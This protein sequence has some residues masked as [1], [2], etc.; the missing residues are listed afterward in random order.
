M[1]EPLVSEDVLELCLSAAKPTYVYSLARLMSTA[2]SI[3]DAFR[4]QAARILFAT[5]A[6]PRREILES[7]ASVGI[8][9]CVNSV[10]HLRASIEAGMP[11]DQIQFTSSGLSVQD[12]RELAKHQIQCNVD[13][14]GQ[15]EA[16]ATSWP[17]GTFGVRINTRLLMGKDVAPH[18]RLGMAPADVPAATSIGRA[19]G[20][21]MNG[22][23]IYIGTNF[24]S[25]AAMLPALDAFFDLA[26][27]VP[28][29]DYVNIGGGM[30][31]DYAME[32]GGFDVEAYAS[33]VA[34]RLMRLST[35]LRRPVQLVVEP[36]R[37]MVASCGFFTCRVTDIKE[38]GGRMFVGVDAS[39]AQ[40][41]RPWHH[42]ETP[43]Q[44]FSAKALLQNPLP[45]GPMREVVIAGRT[46]YSKDVLSTGVLP[47]DLK[48]GDSLIFAHAGAYCDS[49]ASR[50]LGQPE[51]G[52][53]FL[54]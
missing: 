18:D 48:I 8:G 20:S 39:V 38:L 41:P 52:S 6:N 14:L 34:E 42:P 22:L 10:S 40:F 36:G 17:G 43:H 15:A 31:V 21:R 54:N 49:M 51:P 25:H 50:F 33:S 24:E 32:G 45:T 27:T 4:A 35:R 3:Q 9:A 5:M 11:S 1:Q 53:V 19:H 28:D 37:A 29:L 16:Q 7:L 2:L 30:G 26:G 47:S 13:S 46:T 23:H 12:F 44:V